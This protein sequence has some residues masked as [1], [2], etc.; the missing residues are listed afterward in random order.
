MKIEI[1]N[2]G[3][4]IPIIMYDS[5]WQRSLCPMSKIIDTNESVS[6]DD[7]KIHIIDFGALPSLIE[8]LKDTIEQ[9]LII[10]KDVVGWILSFGV[11]KP[12]PTTIDSEDAFCLLIT[13]KNN[14]LLKIKIDVNI[15]EVWIDKDKT[16]EV[17]AT[18]CIQ[19]FEY[20]TESE[21]YMSDVLCKDSSMYF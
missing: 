9:K 4:A 5:V 8:G 6:I 19:I 21:E 7:D 18:R 14:F 10:L 16:I 20:S 13:N 3:P 1:L 15:D 17:R 2:K 12:V 11:V